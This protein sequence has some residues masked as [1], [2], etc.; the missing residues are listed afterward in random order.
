[1]A[2]GRI[3]TREGTGRDLLAFFFGFY[4]D[5]PYFARDR[6]SDGAEAGGAIAAGAATQT[7]L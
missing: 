1:M 3:C 5:L 7:K 2:N 6:R 4:N